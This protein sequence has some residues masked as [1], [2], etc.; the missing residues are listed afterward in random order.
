MFDPAMF[1]E[2]EFHCCEQ[3]K[4]QTTL[5]RSGGVTYYKCTVC[6]DTWSL[7]N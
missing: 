7:S 4:N 3:R 2:P 5:F 6:G 1:D